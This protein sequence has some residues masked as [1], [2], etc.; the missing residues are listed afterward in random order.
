MKNDLFAGLLM[1]V[2]ACGCAG[3]R[4]KDFAVTGVLPPSQARE[5]A[6]PAPRPAASCPSRQPRPGVTAEMPPPVAPAATAAPAR[7]AP[8]RTPLPRPIL[9]PE[10]GLQGKIVSVNPGLR[11]V[12]LNFPVGQMAGP[13]KQLMVFREGKKVGDVK[14]TGPQQ[15]DNIVADLVAGEVQVGDEVR[16]N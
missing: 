7:P 13:E 12:V 1:A 3:T 5:K 15:D 8:S 9:V 16:E 6:E 11:F 4:E 2:I 14:V 10:T